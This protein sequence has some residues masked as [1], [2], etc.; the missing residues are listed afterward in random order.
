MNGFQLG[1][2]PIKLGFLLL[3][4]D[5]Y[6]SRVLPLGLG[7]LAAFLEHRLDYRQIY[8]ARDDSA[9][10]LAQTPD[11]VGLSSFTE[12][13]DQ[14][15]HISKMIKDAEPRVPIVVGGEHISSLPESLPPTVDIGVR[16]EGEETFAELMALFLKRAATPD[17][18]ARIPGIVFRH[19]GKL[20]IT[21]PRE[22]IMDLDQIPPPHRELLFEDDRQHWQQSLFTAR[23]CPY[24]CT[25]CASTQFWQKTRYHSTQR[26]VDEIAGIVAA[27][28]HQDLISISDDLF[29]LNKK[30][31]R[32]ISQAIRARGLHKKVGF[33][34]NAR[35]SVFDD[36][37]AE[38]LLGMNVVGVSF[39][40]E[41]ASDRILKLLKGKTTAAEN[42]RALNLCDKYGF[43]VVGN[44]MVG[45]SE[46]TPADMAK[47]YWFVRQNNPLIWRPNIAF[48]T[49]YPGTEFWQ[50]VCDR[51]LV[52]GDFQQW[53]LL[54]LSFRPGESVFMNKHL[55]S[56]SF[57]PVYDTFVRHPV[58][59]L[60]KAD[61]E[62]E[63]EFKQHQARRDYYQKNH[64]QLYRQ[65]K[66]RWEQ[67][68][69]VGAERLDP[70]TPMTGHTLAIE[71]AQ[72]AWPPAQYPL[73][74]L[75]HALERVREPLTLLTAA[76]TAVA[77]GGYLVIL[78]YNASHMSLLLELLQGRWQS[79]PFSVHP[80]AHL[81]FFALERLLAQVESWPWQAV[82]V[83][84]QQ[85]ASAQWQAV[86]Q[87]LKPLLE[88]LVPLQHL[89][90][91][92]DTF[93]A[94]IVAQKEDLQQCA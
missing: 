45:S 53:N 5:Y 31:L 4:K 15:I 90:Q 61:S 94:L 28:P 33:T 92:Y 11:I 22:W 19:Q 1:E 50:E 43:T 34:C 51:E 56:E 40:F 6:Q 70:L 88:P 67:A 93:S 71:N 83:E 9:R 7:Y 82:Q 81:R 38:L 17:N 13:F 46:E 91:N 12:T 76:V 49:P 25:F 65:F 87:Q 47:T 62:L 24:K 58:L 52:S 18:L 14:V 41:S 79:Q 75:N 84:R 89:E 32:D 36:E 55:S 72:V 66:D 74:I 21:P 59:R 16:G 64:R 8:L 20:V 73:V 60:S 27:F 48:A 77:P 35:A 54:D 39:G 10:L 2:G 57:G 68:V 86:F 85:M 63:T 80:F 78:V 42:Q 44:F 23:G 37:I 3:G 69:E 26:V 29:P 30:R